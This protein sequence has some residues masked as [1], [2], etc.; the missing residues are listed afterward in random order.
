MARQTDQASPVDALARLEA[1]IEGRGA[2]AHPDGA[3]RL[4]ASSL[5]VFRD[6]FAAHL[7]GHCTAASFEPL[8][9]IPAERD[10]WR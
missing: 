5:R 4:L 6:E 9:P 7:R 2:C 3:V 10:D 1:Q 8:L